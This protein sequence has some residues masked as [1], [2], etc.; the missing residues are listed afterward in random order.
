MGHTL[1]LCLWQCAGMI[2]PQALGKRILAQRKALKLN[3]ED[4]AAAAECDRSFIAKME[5]G[6]KT[7]SLETLVL[8]ASGLNTSVGILLGETPLDGF[9]HGVDQL[10]DRQILELWGRLGADDRLM[11]LRMIHAAIGPEIGKKNNVG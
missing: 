5:K 4:L 1:D 7:P 2:D 9:N 11:C 8:L 3:Q 10:E 6:T